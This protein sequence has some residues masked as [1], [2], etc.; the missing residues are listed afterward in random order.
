M[1]GSMNIYLDN[2]AS[3]PMDPEVFEAMRPYFLSHFGNPSSSHAHG[4]TLRNAIEESRRTIA[5]HLGVSPGEICFMSGG[6]EADNMAIRCSIDAYN[7]T[8]V[9]STRIEHH[10]VSHTLEHLEELGEIRVTWLSLDSKGHIDHEELREIL[11]SKPRSLVSLMH[12]NNELG[13]LHDIHA[14]GEI[15]REYEAIFHSDTVQAISHIQ[16]DLSTTPVDMITA[17]AHKFYG[18]KGIGFLYVRK[19]LKISGL[20][21]GGGQERNRRAGT[22][23][24]AS[25][26][27]MAHAFDKG[28]KNFEAKNEKLWGLKNYMKSRLTET[29]RGVSFNGETEEGK[30][31]PTV[32][33]VS[34][35][36]N[37]KDCM[38]LFNLDLAGICVSGGSAC[39]SG[40][41][42]GSFVLREIG[43]EGAQLMNAIR[44]SFGMQNTREE[45]DTVIEKLK[46]YV[47]MPV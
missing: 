38:L 35:P 47:P 30:S 31:I 15:C 7:L 26:V 11:A 28:Y 41:Q 27:G 10:A 33:N 19:G 13:T 20:I 17:S 21:S 3:T 34:L 2:A 32:L 16:Y 14:I 42:L 1:P 9:V 22:E 25:I 29:F 4:R 8:H 23:N 46:E 36:C 6:T 43:V 39:S 37:D 12:A 44:F 5:S 40:A 18:P 24:P 45:I